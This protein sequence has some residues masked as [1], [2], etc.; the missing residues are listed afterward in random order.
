MGSGLEIGP[1]S[2]APARRV[3]AT[4]LAERCAR[5]WFVGTGVELKCETDVVGSF[6]PVGVACLISFA[7]FI[8]WKS[9]LSGADCVLDCGPTLFGRLHQM[10]LASNESYC[11]TYVRMVV[12]HMLVGLIRGVNE[13]PLLSIDENSPAP[14]WSR[15]F[16]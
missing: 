1:S 2:R 13:P 10:Q 16:G 7:A 9:V 4:A 15:P 6:S 5:R 8:R 14:S 11:E 3:R 12:V